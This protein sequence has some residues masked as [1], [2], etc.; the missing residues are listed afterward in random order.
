M[1]TLSDLTVWLEAL[2]KARASGVRSVQHG[3]VRTEYRS[4]AELA[5]AIADI[6]RQMSALQGRSGGVV[7]ISS[8]KGL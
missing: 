8:S 7:Y 2:R 6:E 1:A 5:A 4:D 3:D